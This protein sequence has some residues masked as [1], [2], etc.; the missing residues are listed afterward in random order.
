MRLIYF[1][2]FIKLHYQALSQQADDIHL[3]II[4]DLIAINLIELMIGLEFT[5]QINWT[6]NVL[7][8]LTTIKTI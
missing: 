5:E 2:Y 7:F 1:I 4:L 6:W 8:N 3:S